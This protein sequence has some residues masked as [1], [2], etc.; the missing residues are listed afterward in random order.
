MILPCPNNKNVFQKFI[1]KMWY[2]TY[3]KHFL[4]NNAIYKKHFKKYLKN[5]Y[6]RQLHF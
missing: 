2:A 6:D 1:E 4:Q 5:V 3:K